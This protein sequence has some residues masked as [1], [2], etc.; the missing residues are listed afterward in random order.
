MEKSF[1]GQ[2]KVMENGKG[3]FKS[4]RCTGKDG[5]IYRFTSED[6]AWNMLRICYPGLQ[7]GE[8]GVI[9]VNEPPNMR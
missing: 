5:Y 8:V 3:E 1:E 7:R 9:E 6:A 2:V 4:V